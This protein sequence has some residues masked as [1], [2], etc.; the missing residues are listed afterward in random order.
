MSYKFCKSSCRS[1]TFSLPPIC[2]I[3]HSCALWCAS[4]EQ[5][6]RC[7]TWGRP[8]KC[9]MFYPACKP[10]PQVPSCAA[11][12]PET[13]HASRRP[14]QGVLTLCTFGVLRLLRRCRALVES[15]SLTVTACKVKNDIEFSPL[16]TKVIYAHCEW[17][18]KYRNEDH[19]NPIHYLLPHIYKTRIFFVPA[20]CFFLS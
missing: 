3:L 18:Q 12:Q 20:K 2:K 13:R 17:L 9:Q 15:A 1:L 4:L 5:R 7:G 11:P 6:S 14:W 8:H 16:M 19:F 10:R